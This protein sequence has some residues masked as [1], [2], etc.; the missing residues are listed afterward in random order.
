MVASEFHLGYRCPPPLRPPDNLSGKR[1]NPGYNPD[2]SAP[3]EKETVNLMYIRRVL[4]VLGVLLFAVA[5]PLSA[6]SIDSTL[7]TLYMSY[8]PQITLVVCGSLP[9]TEGCYGSASIGP[10]GRVGAMIEGSPVQNVKKGTVTRFIYV[11]DVAAGSGANQV[12]LY[13][14]KKVDT[15]NQSDDSISVTLSNTVN[16]PLTGG[17]AT[18]AYMAANPT[19]LYIGT[20]QDESAVQVTKKTLALSQ[21][22]EFSGL[23]I[24]AITADAYGYVTLTWGTTGGASGFLVLAPNGGEEEDGGGAPVMLNTTQA[25]LLPAVQ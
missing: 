10:F 2:V 1:A 18:V 19:F 13:I 3:T 20:N 4:A 24:G 25:T 9:Q 16:L 21:I 6:T 23:N 22:G 5:A 15:I 17:A 11:V 14:Y 12:V 7:F 8:P